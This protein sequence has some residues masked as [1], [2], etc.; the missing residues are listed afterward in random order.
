MGLKTLVDDEVASNTVTSVFLPPMVGIGAFIQ[1]LE[2]KGFTVYPGKGPLL[3]NNMFQIA[4]MG[5]VNEEMCRLFLDAMT[6]TL[7]EFNY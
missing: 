3:E 4:N 6:E 2:D 1:S 5:E 7:G